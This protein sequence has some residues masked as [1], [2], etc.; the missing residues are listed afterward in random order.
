MIVYVV[1]GKVSVEARQLVEKGVKHPQ[2]HGIFVVLSVIGSGLVM[3]I[4]SSCRFEK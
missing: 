2:F 4:K 1:W 3:G